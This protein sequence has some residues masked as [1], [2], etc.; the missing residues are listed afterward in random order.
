MKKF[1]MKLKN[2]HIRLVTLNKVLK[3]KLFAVDLIEV[4]K[5]SR[6]NRRM[7]WIDIGE[8]ENIIS[9]DDF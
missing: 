8:E 5:K 2:A 4:M 9:G 3:M 1:R 7:Q 6:A